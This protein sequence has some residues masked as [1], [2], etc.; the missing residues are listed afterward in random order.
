MA[1]SKVDRLCYWMDLFCR[2]WSVGYSQPDR[3]DIYDGGEGDCSSL[4]Y[5]ALW[6]ADLLKRPSNYKTTTH[7][8]GT[9]HKDCVGAGFTAYKPNGRPK[10]GTVLLKTGHVAVCIND[11]G[12]IAEAYASEYGTV[13]GNPGD[14]TGWETRE[15]SYSYTNKWEWY[16]VP[17]ASAY[18]SA[19]PSTEEVDVIQIGPKM[20]R[21]YNSINGDH[22]LT[23]NR[24]EYDALVKSGWKG[25][26]EAMPLMTGMVPIYRLYNPNSGEHFYTTSESELKALTVAG[27]TYESVQGFGVASGGRP[28]YRLYNPSRGGMHHY[29]TSESERDSLKHAGWKYEGEAWRVPA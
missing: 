29:T 7:Y 23:V 11:S 13:D 25:E 8:T 19:A 26:G 4:T 20:Y 9:I 6:R 24:S 15:V 18:T 22:L 17:P 3:W 16:L 1:Q 5:E 14:Q 28:V 2:V 12:T 10:R 27:W 21:A